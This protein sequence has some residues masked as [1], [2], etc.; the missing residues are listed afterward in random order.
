MILIYTEEEPEALRGEGITQGPLTG[1]LLEGPRRW[2]L[3][4]APRTELHMNA[5]V[6]QMA[7]APLM[8]VEEPGLLD[9][10]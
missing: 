5:E 8:A 3:E 6:I 1:A 7:I 4:E 10:E 2:N 9:N